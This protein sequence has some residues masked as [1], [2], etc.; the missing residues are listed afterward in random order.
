MKTKHYSKM[1][2]FIKSRSPV[3]KVIWAISPSPRL[4]I[5]VL[6]FTTS[7]RSIGGNASRLTTINMVQ[8]HV[9]E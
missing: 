9:T 8:S 3:T 7:K 4:H 1:V 5:L 6:V 2:S